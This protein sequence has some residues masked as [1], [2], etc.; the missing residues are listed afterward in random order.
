MKLSLIF[1][2]ATLIT[3]NTFAANEMVDRKSHVQVSI[4]KTSAIDLNVFNNVNQHSF[5]F[6]QRKHS[7]QSQIERMSIE[8]DSIKITLRKR[9]EK[10][11]C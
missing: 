3:V 7:G 10:W 4:M 2:I 6:T 8:S 5:N 1:T 11:Y 9:E